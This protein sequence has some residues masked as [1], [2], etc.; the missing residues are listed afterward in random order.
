MHRRGRG[1]RHSRTRHGLAT[2]VALPCL[3]DEPGLAEQVRGLPPVVDPDSARVAFDALLTITRPVVDRF[4]AGTTEAAA[5]VVGGLTVAELSDASG[6]VGW[7]ASRARYDAIRLAQ[8]AQTLGVS[9]GQI[10]E[11]VRDEPA[12]P[13]GSSTPA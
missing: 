7:L 5:M 1:H 11:V 10:D 3:L 13:P 12:S 6:D 9:N 2:S 4:G 8:H